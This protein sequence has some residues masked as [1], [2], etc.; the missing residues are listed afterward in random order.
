MSI[1]ITCPDCRTTYAIADELHGRKVRCRDCGRPIVVDECLAVGEDLAV[2]EVVDGT[3][4][5][6][7]EP[8]PRVTRAS[9]RE[10]EKG[11]RD[12]NVRKR[13]W[14]RWRIVLGASFL[15]LLTATVLG[16]PWWFDW[17]GV[18][19]LVAD[20]AGWPTLP[21]LDRVSTQETVLL[22]VINVRNEET[23]S[24]ITG[25]LQVSLLPKGRYGMSYS[26]VDDRM[27]ILVASVPDPEAFAKQI[28]FGTV[29]RVDGRTILVVAHL[30][31]E[32]PPDTD[33]VTRALHDL[34]S[35]NTHR[36]MEAAQRLSAMK[37]NERRREVATALE[38]KLEDPQPAVYWGAAEALG[39]WGDEENVPGLIKALMKK[40]ANQKAAGALAKIKDVRAIEPIAAALEDFA[41]SSDAVEALPTFGVAAEDAVLK[42]LNHPDWRV[43][44]RTCK[45]LAEIGTRKSVAALQD[46]AA[47]GNIFVAPDARLALRAIRDRE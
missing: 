11:P 29:Y 2:V 18:N 10:A 23:A 35:V 19:F 1:R 37:P 14:G 21:P 3:A 40:P 30:L 46:L 45:V 44:S 36:V 32:L 15:A 17:F 33:P 24:V 25:K 8:R 9:E 6:Q 39:V 5:L 12:L 47:E 20:H 43:R 7:Q 31:P 38:R 41:T 13:G 22:H 28:D 27:A 4:T 26:R 16:G 42:R 34:E